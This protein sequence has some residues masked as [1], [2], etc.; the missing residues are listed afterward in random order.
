LRLTLGEVRIAAAQRLL[1]TSLS[2]GWVAELA[3]FDDPHYF[4]RVFRRVVGQ[5][6]QLPPRG[7]GTRPRRRAALAQG[8]CR[9]AQREVQPVNEIRMGVVGL[10]SRGVGWIRLLQQ[11]KGYRVTA[12][13]V[14]AMSTR[15]PS[16]VH[17]EIAQPDM[18]VALMKTEK[19]AIL[20]MATSF[21]QPNPPRD[22]HWYQLVGTRGCV[23]WK[24]S[25]REL[26]KLWLADSQM[27]GMAEVDWRYERADAPSE[28]GG[29][30]HGDADYYVHAAFRDA[31]LGIKPPELD[32]Y[33]AVETAAPAILAAE[34]I[35]QG[36]TLLRVPDFRPG[37][38]GRPGETGDG[39]AARHASPGP[40]S[41][42]G[43]ELMRDPDGGV[44]YRRERSAVVAC[45]QESAN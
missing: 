43:A 33:R 2:V 40:T 24:R 3:G 18:Q 36:S 45:C 27:H 37:A 23:E 38:T 22:C 7:T 21:T 28:A 41:G 25:R 26:S 12:V 44:H 34:S 20:R 10:G 30:G 35:A 1:A 32:V 4:S 42:G 5:H 8:G 13:E 19:G 15:S 29:S 17:P 6:A 31:V 39:Q 11:T 14:T 16:Y 9:Q